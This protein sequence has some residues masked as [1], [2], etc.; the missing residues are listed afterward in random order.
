MSAAETTEGWRN[1]RLP[2]S[3][4]GSGAPLRKSIAGVPMAPAAATNVRARTIT[5]RD[6]GAVPAASMAKPSSDATSS[7]ANT[8]RWARTRVTSVAPR[9][10]AAGIVVTSIDCF[11]LVGHP[12]P[13]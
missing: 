12:M 6:V 3:A 10:S 1:V 11:A 5:L 7:P 9:S 4:C 8:K 13:Q 2:T